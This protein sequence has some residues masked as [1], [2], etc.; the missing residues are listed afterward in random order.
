MFM[1]PYLGTFGAVD[2]LYSESDC[3]QCSGGSYCDVPGLSAPA[4]SCEEGFYCSHGLFKRTFACVTLFSE[5]SK[6]YC[7]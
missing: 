2:G 1:N 3:S 6:N 7:Y 5:I 4:G